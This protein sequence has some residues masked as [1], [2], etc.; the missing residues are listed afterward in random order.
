M[1]CQICFESF[2]CKYFVPK[3][4]VNCGHSFCKICIERLVNKK[5]IITCPICREQTNIIRDLKE[6]LPTNYSLVEI[7]D[8][9]KHSDTT[10][11]ILEKYKFF[12]D[13]SY[14]NIKSKITRY[15]DP[16]I[17]ELK[18]IVNDDFI[19]IEEFENNQN[20]SL[21]NSSIIR[22]RR[23]N[24]NKYSMFRFLFNEYSY[25]LF[26]YRKSSKC[27]HQFSCLEAIIKKMFYAICFSIFCYYP[28]KTL[29]KNYSFLKCY[30][31]LGYNLKDSTKFNS[32]IDKLLFIWQLGIFTCISLPK[33]FSCI[34]GYYID[35]ILT[36]SS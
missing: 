34:I 25:F 23:Y 24:F 18:K 32:N 10:K 8:K 17:L 1:D 35:E 9:S 22:N 5:T 3:M 28:M 12:E 2:D 13:K 15:N 31:N 26:V 4:L 21:F 16:K 14:S 20:I 19:Y 27:K 6:G 29:F 36:L 7:I 33:I 11:N 30:L